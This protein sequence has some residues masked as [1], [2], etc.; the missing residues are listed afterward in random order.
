MRRLALAASPMLALL[1]LA[2]PAGAAPMPT[3]ATFMAFIHGVYTTQG[4]VINTG[5]WRPI[6]E[7]RTEYFTLSGNASETVLFGTDRPARTQVSN[8]AGDFG[9]GS[10]QSI[11]LEA[12]ITR[13]NTLMSDST[14]QPEGCIPAHQQVGAP[15]KDCGIKDKFYGAKLFGRGRG[16]FGQ[17]GWNFLTAPYPVPDPYVGCRLVAGQQWWGEVLSRLTR[18]SKSLLL[19]PRVRRVVVNGGHAGTRSRSQGDSRSSWS[20]R[21][22]WTITLLRVRR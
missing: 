18:V 8:I 20:Y 7:D 9:A 22:R 10:F 11:R 13:T 14:T 1:A 5:C 15:P 6:S 17:L 4:N 16:P 21:L 19:R 3:R 12:Q 2:P